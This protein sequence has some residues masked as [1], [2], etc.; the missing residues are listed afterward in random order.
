MRNLS[1]RKKIK[2]VHVITRFD[3]G[4]SAENTYLTVSGLDRDTYDISL[5]FGSSVERST[6]P[7]EIKSIEE[8]I[9]HLRE[10]GIEIV[11]LPYLTRPISPIKDIL[12]LTRLYQYFKKTKPVIVHTHT[13]KA[14]ILGRFAAYLARTPIICHTPHGHV[15]W[16]YFSP[17]ETNIFILLEKIAARITDRLIML[18]PQERDDH[19]LYHIAAP[20]KFEIIHSGVDLLPFL[21]VGR[22]ERERMR[23]AMSIKEDEFVVGTVGRLTGIKGH[24]YLLS[25]FSLFLRMGG[26][27]ILII[28]GDGELRSDLEEKARVLKISDRVHFLGWR[29]DV[30][31]IMASFDVFVLPSL[32]E[33]MGKVIVEA[34]AS[35]LPIIASQIGGIKNLVAPGENGFLTPPGDE[36]NLAASLMILYKQP[37]KRA[38]MGLRGREKAALYSKEAMVEKIDHLYRT[39]LLDSKLKI[40]VP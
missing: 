14:G 28:V 35:G 32:N 25:A 22:S 39:L 18:T 40:I 8:N 37:H 34:M 33:G 6:S 29:R 3:K 36:E 4:G 16:G 13:S 17:L 24:R 9:S 31:D 19:L 27:G 5:M 15:F 38:E 7:A 26:E 23:T 2:V 11:H 12:A 1:A 20:E 10:K 30:A 21:K